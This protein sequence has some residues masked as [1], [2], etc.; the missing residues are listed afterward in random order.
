MTT[1]NIH[2]NNTRYM[3]LHVQLDMNLKKGFRLNKRQESH[4]TN[5]YSDQIQNINTRYLSVNNNVKRTI[6][7]T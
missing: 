6:P 2:N 5:Q 3:R 1:D 7:D 4:M